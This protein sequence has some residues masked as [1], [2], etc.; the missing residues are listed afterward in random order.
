VQDPG[1]ARIVRELGVDEHVELR[2]LGDAD[3][4]GVNSLP[5]KEDEEI[6]TL[7]SKV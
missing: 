1:A 3:D 5:E 2:V 6:I 7:S 4:P